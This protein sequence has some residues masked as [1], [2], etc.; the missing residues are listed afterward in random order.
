MLSY[1]TEVR[2]YSQ[3]FLIR[4]KLLLANVHLTSH[5]VNKPYEKQ[6][7]KKRTDN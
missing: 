7:E 1:I 3:V 4:N 2:Y 6:I 5:L